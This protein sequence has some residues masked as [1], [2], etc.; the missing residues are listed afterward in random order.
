MRTTLSIAILMVCMAK[1][2]AQ[3]TPDLIGFQYSEFEKYKKHKV[4]AQIEK[5]FDEFT[6]ELAVNSVTIYSEKGQML[7]TVLN[8]ELNSEEA[9]DTIKYIYEYNIDGNIQVV[10]IYGL[11]IVPMMYGF[12]YDK[13]GR[14]TES[15]IASAEARRI[16]YE[17]D[18]KGQV[19]KAIANGA[20]F[21]YDEEG[22]ASDDYTWMPME[23][24]TYEW[25]DKGWLME[26]RSSYRTEFSYHAIY[27][28]DAEGKLIE[29]KFCYDAEHPDTASTIITFEY[30]QDGLLKKRIVSAPDSEE[31]YESVFEYTFYN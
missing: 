25:N 10:T 29:E 19:V 31:K 21:E 3:F 30:D 28:Y 4:K 8:P 2:Q 11:D 23:E 14:L 27:V 13:K 5:V 26:E 22:N 7:Q 9:L 24:T 15:N 17:L 18:K 16:Y 20:V 12:F 1:A 6:E